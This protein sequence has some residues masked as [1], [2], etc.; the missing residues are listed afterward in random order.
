MKKA[1]EERQII[2]GKRETRKLEQEKEKKIETR[3]R[4]RRRR[5]K[6][7]TL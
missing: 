1:K 6:T 7:N 5:D 3:R 4:R 2:K